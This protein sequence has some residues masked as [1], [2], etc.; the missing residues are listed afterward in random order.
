MAPRQPCSSQDQDIGEPVV[1]V[2]R[3][4]DI[5]SAHETFQTG[6]HRSVLECPVP[7]VFEVPD[8]VSES[9]GRCHDVD[10]PVSVE[11]RRN[12]STGESLRVEPQLRGDIGKPPDV[13]RGAYCLLGDP[14]LDGYAVWIF[15]DHHICDVE[16]P[17]R[18]EIVGI[19]TK[20][21]F[22]DANGRAC[23][24]RIGMAGLVRNGKE[25]RGAAQLGA[26]VGHLSLAQVRDGQLVVDR[27]GERRWYVDCSRR[28]V[29]SDVLKGCDGLF[30]GTGRQ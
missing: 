4:Q 16:Q 8:L 9:S 17:M 15:T 10:V 7:V 28:D 27:H 13:V 14:P 29:A 21:C 25:T 30:E 20:R 19:V 2:V 22:V 12:A 1:V 26:T 3:G 24:R 5:Q 6:G 23:R 18:Y 11:V